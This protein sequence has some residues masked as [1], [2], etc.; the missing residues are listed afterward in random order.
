V[1]LITG[2][3]Y[4]CLVS[5]KSGAIKMTRKNFLSCSVEFPLLRHIYGIYEQ[6]YLEFVLYEYFLIRTP[7]YR[8]DNLSNSTTRI[9]KNL[10]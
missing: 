4:L 9:T 6:L 1:F 8:A 7:E 2:L 10:V 5:K 3:L